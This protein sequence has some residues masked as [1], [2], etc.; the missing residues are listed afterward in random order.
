VISGISPQELQL[1]LDAEQQ[2]IRKLKILYGKWWP[3]YTLPLELK[4]T[5]YAEH[6]TCPYCSTALQMPSGIE[7]IGQEEAARHIDHMDPL[8]RGGEESFRNAIC[9]CAKCN[10]AKGKQLFANWLATLPESRQ[11][12]VR[13][14]YVEKLGRSPEQFQPGPKQLRLVATRLELAFDEQVL[15]V[16]YPKPVVNGPPN[17][18]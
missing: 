1:R 2:T 9:A 14:I 7:A 17:R 12:A 16:L 4:W 13:A 10:M 15:R 11:A 3:H 18:Q 5:L 8:S 6:D